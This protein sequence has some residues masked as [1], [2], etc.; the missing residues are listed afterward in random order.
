MTDAAQVVRFADGEGYERF[1]GQWSRA[2]GRFFLDW[3]S[4]PSGLK[5]LDVGCGTGAF[6]EIIK[7]S[8]GASE[9]RAIDP[10]T[11]QISYAQSRKGAE[12]IQFQVADARSMPFEDERF[13]V[14]ASAL[15][16]N[17]ISDREKAVSEMRRVV[18]RGG[19]AAAYVWDFANRRG[20]SQH[21]HSAVMELEGPGYRPAELNAEST[22]PENL[23]A[24]FDA[25]GLTDV[26]TRS[27]E[28]SVTHRDFD[29]Y[30]DSH[31]K[32]ASPIGS[33]IQSMTEENR[34]RLKQMV[35][36]R[37]PIDD[38]GAISFTAWVNA[39]KGSV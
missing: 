9:I 31:T 11:A 19:T 22:T 3:L 17:F 16:L 37:L 10:A 1:M 26:V 6:T 38:H 33:H 4:L 2:A 21:L 8:S 18:R 30:W 15:V 35:R 34:Q 13:G 27:F 12:G 23:K 7:E 20:T 28:I 5:W 36:A 14:A 25:A 39:V 29:D 24:L 32:F